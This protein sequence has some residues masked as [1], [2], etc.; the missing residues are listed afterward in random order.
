MRAITS[1]CVGVTLLFPIVA[2]ADLNMQPGLWESTMTVGGNTMPAEQK[3]YQQKDIDALDRFQR[4]AD[5]PGQ[6]P[7]SSSG[8]KA[9]GNS[10]TYTLTCQLNGRKSVSAVTT[11]YDGDRITGT[12]SGVDGTISRLVNS[13][14]GD[15]TDSSF[16]N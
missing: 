14:I 7:C 5:P 3:C 12:I 9:L 2:R 13:R 4:G 1:A 11:T 15:C 16:G 8:Y 6:T 10:M